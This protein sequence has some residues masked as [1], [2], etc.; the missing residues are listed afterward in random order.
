M[1]RDD[2]LVRLGGQIDALLAG[3][4]DGD[5]VSDF[6]ADLDPALAAFCRRLAAAAPAPR[7]DFIDVLEA[8]LEP[9]AQ[10]KEESMFVRRRWLLRLAIAALILF[11]FVSL[12]LAVDAILLRIINLDPGL[13]AVQEA[14]K[15]QE[16]D[17]TQTVDGITVHVQ[18]AYADANRVSIGYTISGE[19]ILD[20]PAINYY[21]RATLTD[22]DGQALNSAGGIGHT[23]EGEPGAEVD[24]FDLASLDPLPDMLDLRLTLNVETMTADSFA[25]LDARPTPA[26]DSTPV[27]EA[28]TPGNTPF[29]GPF[30]PF[31]F[32]F[33]IPVGE[34]RI[35]PID[36]T[37]TDQGATIRFV[38]AILSPSQTR[39]E[40]CLTPPNPT[41]GGWA[42]IPS[43]V[44]NGEDLT[45]PPTMAIGEKVLDDGT[46]GRDGTESCRQMIFEGAL[47]DRTGTWLFGVRELV[48]FG[49]TGADNLQTRISGDWSATFE[50]Q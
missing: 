40:F 26:P 30:G 2:E 8:R 10:L 38:R 24:S 5:P 50:V 3:D 35:I 47:A 45:N 49:A 43:L 23:G 34:G 31:E 12:A 15:G 29:S 46:S 19:G 41:E 22:A 20:S 18:W 25:T 13:H 9:T 14:G 21:P 48:G 17:L 27:V 44:I 28:F 1:S 42:T 32:A 11:G 7:P 6:A 16:L 39:I 37:V 4:P 36:Q 33:T